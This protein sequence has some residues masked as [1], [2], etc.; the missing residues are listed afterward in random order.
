MKKG[1]RNIFTL[2]F[3]V[4]LAMLV[5]SVYSLPQQ[6]NALC[7]APNSEANSYHYIELTGSAAADHLDRLGSPLAGHEQ[8]FVPKDSDCSKANDAAGNVP[9]PSNGVPEPVAM[10]LFGTGLAGLGYASRRYFARGD[11]ESDGEV[12]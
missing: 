4:S 2:V 10:L 7:H 1:P 3:V 12:Q 5:I 11:A 6:P 9:D 8:D